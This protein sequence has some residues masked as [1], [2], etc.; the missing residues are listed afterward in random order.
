MLSKDSINENFTQDES[1]NYK[2]PGR[3]SF[4]TL[5]QRQHLNDCLEME[6]RTEYQQRI[7]IM[8]LAD[9]G[10]SQAKICS[11][12]NCAQETA[13]F[14]IFMAKSGQ[15]QSWKSIPI[16]RPKIISDEHLERLRELVCHSPRE[17][18]Y[19]FQKWTARWL[20]T[21]LRNEYDVQVSDRHIS[22]LLKQIGFSTKKLES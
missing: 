15:T 12:L 4:L 6:L 3:G 7:K 9:A 13:R 8:L 2:Y 18:G 10:L 22:R 11:E 16:G 20:N 1:S 21:H 17:Y 14:W 5:S 19:P